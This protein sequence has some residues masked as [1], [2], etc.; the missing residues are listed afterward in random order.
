MIQVMVIMQDYFQVALKKV[1]A[2]REQ[3][4]KIYGND[5]IY[6]EISYSIWNAWGKTQRATHILKHG[7]NNYEKMEDTLRDNIIYS[8]FALAILEREKHEK[9]DYGH[10]KTRQKNLLRKP[11]RK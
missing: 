10:R 4:Q 9:T 3:R 6:D 11:R 8:L 1:L 7:N 2:L 5:W